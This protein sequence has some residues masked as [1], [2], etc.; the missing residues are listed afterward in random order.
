MLTFCSFV[1]P[2]N[3]KPSP[4]FC[5]TYKVFTQAVNFTL[6]FSS[7]RIAGKFSNS[8]TKLLIQAKSIKVVVA[9]LDKF[10]IQ[11]MTSCIAIIF[12]NWKYE[13]FRVEYSQLLKTRTFFVL[14][15]WP[16]VR[17]FGNSYFWCC[18]LDK[19]L[20]FLEFFNLTKNCWQISDWC[21]NFK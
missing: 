19:F 4:Q 16:N 9:K 11:S 12:L 1:S 14:D 2:N 18:K 3:Q 8:E 21:P 15:F 5:W 7:W 13:S 20:R 17:I 6:P 10:F